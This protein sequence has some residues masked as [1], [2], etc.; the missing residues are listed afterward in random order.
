VFGRP[1]T[2]TIVVS[3]SGPSIAG[4]VVVTALLPLGVSPLSASLPYSTTSN[5][6]RFTLGT[7]PVGA[8]QT[9][10]LVIS[11][12]ADAA[13]ITT[14]FNVDAFNDP[15]PTN[16]VISRITQISTLRVWLPLAAR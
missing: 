5:A 2:Y 10:T 4:G 11:A 14:T 7:L 8:S 15:A 12:P 13:S 9:I 1:I 6:F 16:N 3:N